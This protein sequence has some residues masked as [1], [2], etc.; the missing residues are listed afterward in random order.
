L[1]KKEKNRLEVGATKTEALLAD[2][3]EAGGVVV[4]DFLF[5]GV[6]EREDE[7]CFDVAADGYALSLTKWRSFSALSCEPGFSA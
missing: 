6:G 4:E 3:E 1:P 5:G 7:E 2:R